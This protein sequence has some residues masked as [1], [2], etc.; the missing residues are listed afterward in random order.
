M[1]STNAAA[2]SPY[3]QSSV[4]PQR[5]TLQYHYHHRSSSSPPNNNNQRNYMNHPHSSLLSPSSNMNSTSLMLNNNNT[6]TSSPTHKG[7]SHLIV[8]RSSIVRHKEVNDS[9]MFT[10]TSR[11]PSTTR[12][13]SLSSPKA[14][15]ASSNSSNNSSSSTSPLSETTSSFA[16]TASI[17]VNGNS[18]LTIN[19]SPSYVNSTNTGALSQTHKHPKFNRMHSTLGIIQL[20]NHSSQYRN[21][22]PSLANDEPHDRQYCRS[23]LR[24]TTSTS[25]LLSSNQTCNEGSEKSLIIG[26]SSLVQSPPPMNI[27]P[28][29]LVSPDLD[30]SPFRKPSLCSARKRSTF[31]APSMDEEPDLTRRSSFSNQGQPPQQM[32]AHRSA[33][34]VPG[35]YSSRSMSP[36][37][38]VSSSLICQAPS[39]PSNSACPSTSF[40]TTVTFNSTEKTSPTN[41]KQNQ[42][43][44][45]TNSSFVEKISNAVETQRQI[46]ALRDY[47]KLDSFAFG[48]QNEE[49]KEY[50]AVDT[51]NDEL[52]YGK[53]VDMYGD[54]KMLL[55][56]HNLVKEYIN[57]KGSRKNVD[58]VNAIVMDVLRKFN[59]RTLKKN[60]SEATIR[61]FNLK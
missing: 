6:A 8:R 48:S 59:S 13:P 28:S 52:L 45:R 20:R 5:S 25:S 10:E 54:Q 39:M 40:S 33:T 12:L 16:S 34:P 3:H 47:V 9:T 7:S 58:D 23:P 51:K 46:E 27:H 24:S 41:A 43:P 32:D 36:M 22:N 30:S 31:Q 14:A 49:Y 11:R 42:E 60:K 50:S 56:V 38:M 37:G 29:L 57:T 18:I 61:T 1:N 2:S 15:V 26:P 19:S 53:Y 35:G 55:N 4:R 17:S 44:K 21:S